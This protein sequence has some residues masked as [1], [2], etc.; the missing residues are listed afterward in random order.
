VVEFQSGALHEGAG[1]GE[2]LGDGAGAGAGAGDGAGE[3]HVV[4]AQYCGVHSGGLFTFQAVDG[5]IAPYMIPLR[6]T[7]SP[8]M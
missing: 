6:I 3:L 7:V 4:T 5:L 2:G 8:G 1:A